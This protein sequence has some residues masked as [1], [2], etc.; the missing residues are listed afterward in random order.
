MS[1]VLR[2]YLHVTSLILIAAPKPLPFGILATWSHMATTLI[3]G[4][5]N[6]V[7]V[8]PPLTV[9]Q[10]EKLVAW[11]RSVIVKKTLQTLYFTHGHGDHYLAIGHLPRHI[12]NAVVM[13]TSNTIE[14]METQEDGYWWDDFWTAWL[15]GQLEKP[16]IGA[17]R[18]LAP[19]NLIHLEGQQLKVVE[20]GHS[21]IQDSS[22]LHVLELYMMVAGDICYNGFH[23]W[24][25]EAIMAEKRQ[26]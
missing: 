17:I 6:A 8:E 22:F 24:L 5:T 13:A 2:A 14:H 21:D 25:V 18:P 12:A 3:H 10:G 11:I 20:A 19:D 16:P 23:Q 7:L 15:L 4:H 1:S 26:A 9:Q